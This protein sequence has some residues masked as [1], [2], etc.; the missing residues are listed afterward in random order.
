MTQT[1]LATG[2]GRL[3]VLRAAYVAPDNQV[4]KHHHHC[5]EYAV[6]RQAQRIDWLEM[7]SLQWALLTVLDNFHMMHEIE[8]E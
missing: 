8:R 6:D 2:F 7:L 3:L 1:K 4:K 5:V